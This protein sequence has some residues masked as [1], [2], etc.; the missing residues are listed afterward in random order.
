MYGPFFN[1]LLIVLCDFPDY[2]FFLLSMIYLF[3]AAFGERV[4]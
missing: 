4:L 2:Y 1:D 3:E